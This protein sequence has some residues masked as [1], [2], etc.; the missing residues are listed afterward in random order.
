MSASTKRILQA[1][2]PSAAW[3]AIIGLES[4]SLGSAEHSARILYP[5]LH[6]LFA[7]N[8]ARFIFWHFFLRKVGH[9]IGYFT[10]SILL[11]RSWRISATDFADRWSFHWAALAFVMTAVVAAGDEWHQSFVPSRTS[12]LR[13]VMLDTFAGL[14]AQISL[15]LVLRNRCKGYSKCAPQ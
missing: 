1:W 9:F 13:D 11:F 15:F 14:I 6:F 8:P 2:L 10:L 4:T 12:S 7:M 5:I 3:L